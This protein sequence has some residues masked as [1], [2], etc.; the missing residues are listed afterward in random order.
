VRL[1]ERFPETVLQRAFAAYMIVV[2]V[3]MIFDAANGT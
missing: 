3:L 2:A 1:R